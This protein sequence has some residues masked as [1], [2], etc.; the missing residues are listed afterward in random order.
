MYENNSTC[1]QP[2]TSTKVGIHLTLSSTVE[3]QTT[4]SHFRV[5]GCVCYVFVP[6]HLRS[7]INKKATRCIF[8]GYDS[9]RK[10]WRCCDPTTSRCYTSRNVVFNEASSWWSSQEVILPDSKEIKIKLQE[11]LG[12]Q[13]QEEEK[14]TSEQGESGQPSIEPTSDGNSR[15]LQNPRK[16][17]CIFKPQKKIDQAKLQIQSAQLRK[18]SRQRKDNPKYANAALAGKEKIPKEPAT[19]KEAV[20]SKK[21]RN[22]IDKEIQVL[23]QN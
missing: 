6:D 22:A 7:K 19:Y 15:S 23:K 10:G 17:A 1:H 18:S 16:M 2:T 11:K 12:E 9:E 21:W 20:T 4:V 13:V 3:D 5:F 14:T 8:V